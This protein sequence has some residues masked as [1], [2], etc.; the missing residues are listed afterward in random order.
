[1]LL[2]AEF[3]LPSLRLIPELDVTIASLMF[4]APDLSGDAVCRLPLLLPLR[5]VIRVEADSD[6]SILL[7]F[8]PLKKTPQIN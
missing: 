4:P 5:C 7:P 6:V 8:P 1:M 2:A 3:P